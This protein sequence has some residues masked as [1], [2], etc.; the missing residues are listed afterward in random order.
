VENM[1]GLFS[2]SIFN[3]DISQWNVSKVTH[4]NNLFY[5]SKFQ[6]DITNWK[7]LS[8]EKLRDIFNDSYENKPY[9]V[10]YTS[11]DE[12]NKAIDSYWLHK[13]L[14]KDLEDNNIVQKRVKI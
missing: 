6:G 5:D 11:K 4:M 9:W 10:N 3:G 1:S 14:K 2:E 12:R 7:P 8:L 13:E